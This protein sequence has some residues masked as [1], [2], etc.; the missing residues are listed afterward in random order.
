MTT[1]FADQLLDINREMM[2][3]GLNAVMEGKLDAWGA[4]ARS[5]RDLD[6]DFAKWWR[7]SEGHL[8]LGWILDYMANRD[9]VMYHTLGSIEDSDIC[10][11][12]S[13][14]WDVV[15]TSMEDLILGVL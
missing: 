8:D 9:D 15:R 13:N 1:T 4:A 12:F 2:K 3:L 7:T 6:Q 10:A 11:K 5:L 14:G